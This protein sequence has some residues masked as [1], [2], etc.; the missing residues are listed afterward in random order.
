MI[1]LVMSTNKESQKFT[2]GPAT[3]I[4]FFWPVRML[5]RMIRISRPPLVGQKPVRKPKKKQ[6]VLERYS[7]K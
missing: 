4:Y 1:R 5:L 2:Q 6:K 7:I 3:K